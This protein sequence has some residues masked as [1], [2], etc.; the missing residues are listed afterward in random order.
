MASWTRRKFLGATAGLAALPVAEGAAAPKIARRPLGKTGMHVSIL[1]LGGGSQFLAACKTD[2][3]AVALLNTAIDGGINYLDSAWSYG[4]GESLRRYGLVVPKRR[5]EVYVTSKTLKRDRDGALREVEA[6]L[7]NLKSDHLDLMQIHLIQP[8]EDLDRLLAVDGVFR[9]L[10]KLKEE[11]TVRAVGITGHLAALKMKTLVERMEGLDTVLCP[12]NPFRDSRHYLPERNPEEP[13]GHFEELLLPAAREKGLGI[14]GM[15]VFAQ[16]Q[17]VGEGP[18]KMSGTNLL[19]YAMS[20]PGV[21]TVI[22]GPGNMAF[23]QENLKTAQGFVPMPGGERRKF[24]REVSS[25]AHRIAYRE[26][27]YRGA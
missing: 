18:G 26:R 9:A 10:L 25:V 27:G 4:D 12:V 21:S 20:A 5:G 24:A 14:I 1:G 16:G 13:N 22:A 2:D 17:L 15:K 8:D 3:E 6:S 19:R 7:K 11:K 23:L